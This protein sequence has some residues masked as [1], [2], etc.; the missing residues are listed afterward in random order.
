MN[1]FRKIYCFYRDG[2]A[3]MTIGRSLWLLIII[4]VAVLFLVLKL[5]FFPNVIKEESENSGE[6]PENIV[7]SNLLERTTD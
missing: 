4:K 7:R 1:I 3:G 2:F 6:T 5:F